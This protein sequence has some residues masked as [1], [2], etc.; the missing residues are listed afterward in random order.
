[1]TYSQKIDQF[2]KRYHIGFK[3]LSA[4]CDIGQKRLTE[5]MSGQPPTKA[6]K[7][8][9]DVV[10]H[11]LKCSSHGFDFTDEINYQKERIKTIEKQVEGVIVKLDVSAADQIRALVKSIE[12]ES[13]YL[14][15]FLANSNQVEAVEEAVREVRN[16]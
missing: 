9:L 16:V 15:V 3:R 1:M 10:E 4:M 11:F 13:A 2:Y 12:A 5:I 8:L 7:H 6:E 14:G